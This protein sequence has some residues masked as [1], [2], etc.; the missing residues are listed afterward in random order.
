MSARAAARKPAA[1]GNSGLV[2]TLKSTDGTYD[3]DS[4]AEHAQLVEE[5]KQQ[6]QKAETASE[7]YRKETDMLQMRLNEVLGE[8]DGLENQISQMDAEA[9]AVHAEA[10]DI[11]RQKKDLEQAHNA[12]KALMLKERET[13][14]NTEQEL[15]GVIQRLN[16]T[17]KQKEMRAHVEGDRA[18]VSRSG[19]C[20]RVTE[21]SHGL[22]DSAASFRSRASPDLDPGQFAPSAQ[23]DRSSSR[24][25]STLLLQKDKMVESLQLE[26]AEAQ[27]KLAEIEHMGDG[28][29]Q[30]IEK[31]LL[32][33]R[34]ANARLL[35]DNESFQLLLSEKTLKGDFLQETR[36]QT[37][38]AIGTLA[39]E[40]E[41]A[42]DD[43]EGE[44]S[45]T[46]K[47][48]EAELKSSRD[49]NKA[50]TLYIDKII[51]KLLQ[52]EGFEHIIH[53]KDEPPELPAKPTDKALPPPPPGEQAPSFLQR[54]RS[55]VSGRAGRPLPKTRPLS[56]MPP[57]TVDVA[58][59]A[60]E[61]PATA[62]SIPL[63]RGGHR[64]ARSDQV[65]ENPA[66]TV[67]VGQ[68]RRESPLR[69]SSGGPSS[70]GISP[71]MS[72]STSSNR[73]PF[74]FSNPP[75]SRITSGSGP[76]TAEPRSR[77]N[78]ILSQQSG[79]VNSQGT[80]SPP[81][82][83]LGLNVLP[84]AVVKQNQLRPL[85]LVREN[86]QLEDDEAARKKANR[87]SWMPAW[88]NR[89]GGVENEPIKPWI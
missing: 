64:R 55:V 48:L 51:G 4:R 87:G 20:V 57:A 63:A 2:G 80:H 52:H 38:A 34:M 29:L 59:T 44:S 27:I 9:E 71:T 75:S 46:Y 56:Y 18:G 65:T 33:T 36:P 8:R 53:E 12:E 84:G 85:R 17:M 61:N 15:Q 37:A 30:E 24:N 78:S 82:E 42:G 40:L 5:L 89:A 22:I 28:R 39:D 45:K 26:L 11:L 70:P 67:V 76:P 74:V 60:H 14:L 19:M 41:S 13:Q 3:N 72:P 58:A 1:R 79:E 49:S 69:T 83:K 25:N 50:L 35:E 68:T 43:G 54:A 88:F 73:S 66:A 86:T 81:R 21:I 7:Q 23:L 32:D 6:V 62:P 47:K 31:Q 16:E 77:T 10:K